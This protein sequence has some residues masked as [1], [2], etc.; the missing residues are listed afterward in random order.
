MGE[1][2]CMREEGSRRDRESKLWEIGSRQARSEQGSA[3]AGWSE[4]ARELGS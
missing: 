1:L 4:G 2:R 3:I